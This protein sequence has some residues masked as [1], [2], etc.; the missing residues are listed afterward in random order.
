MGPF[1]CSRRAC[2]YVIYFPGC[3]V[4][5]VLAGQVRE[6]DSRA[7]LHSR[8]RDVYGWSVP[9]RSD[10]AQLPDA[11]FLLPLKPRRMRADPA[12]WRAVCVCSGVSFGEPPL[13]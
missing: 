5:M 6:R 4:L 11:A 1:A 3:S 13:I 7:A 9:K 8:R 10:A 2:T 12:R